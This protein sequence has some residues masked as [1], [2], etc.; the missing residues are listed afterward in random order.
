[1]SPVDSASTQSST[2]E[3]GKINNLDGMVWYG[4]VY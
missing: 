1:M 2:S 4:M 3:I